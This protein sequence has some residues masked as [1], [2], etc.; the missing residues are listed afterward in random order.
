[1]LANE[2][3]KLCHGEAESKRAENEAKIILSRGFIDSSVIDNCQQKITIKKEKLN[4]G[5]TIKQTLIDLKLTS[6]NGESKRLIT[7]GG[8]KINDNII[9]NKDQKL[10][11]EMFKE[12]PDLNSSLYVII[13][14]GKKKYGIVELIS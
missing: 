14:L 7:Q 12:I 10:D 8:V 6:S 9:N 11:I 3:T 2:V 1:M 5:L 13:Y 4:E